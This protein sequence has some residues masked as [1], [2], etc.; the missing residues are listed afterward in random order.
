MNRLFTKHLSSFPQD[1]QVK[2]ALLSLFF[3]LALAGGPALAQAEH[4]R[5]R[6]E[7][8]SGRLKPLAEILGGVQQRHGGRVID[9]ELERGAGGRR[10]YEIKLFNGQRVTLYVDAVT[11]AEIPRPDAAAPNLLP[12]SAVVR[13][14]LA[15][16]PGLV[17]EA[18][19]EDDP[20]SHPYY[21]L[22]LMGADGRQQLLRVDARTGR[23]ITEPPVPLATSARIVPVDRVLDA[24]EKRFKARATEAELKATRS[25][26][27]YY[28]IDLQLESGRSMEVHADAETGRL[29]EEEDLR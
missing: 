5:V 26:R 15:S 16:H 4:D 21:E 9:I 28:E 12:M 25:G 22:K 13:G 10:W 7:V 8:E 11:G 3:S 14:V 29:I 17:L 18:E 6:R 19:L 1:K 23:Q 20:A 24:L 2:P 27:I